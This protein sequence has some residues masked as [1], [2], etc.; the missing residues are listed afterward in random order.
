VTPNWDYQVSAVGNPPQKFQAMT[1]R[2]HLP[3]HFPGYETIMWMDADTWIQR[4]SAVEH[5][6]DKAQTNG[7][8]ICQE[9]DRAY[10]NVYDLNNSRV[11]FH[12]SLAIFGDQVLQHVGPLPMVNSGVFAMRSDCKYWSE[13]NA[14]LGSAIQRGHLDH[15]TEQT[16]LNVCVYRALPLPYFMPAKFNWLCI[17]A[18][19]KF[20]DQAML[21]VDPGVP[22]D[23]I[24]IIH[25]A[26]VH[27]RSKKSLVI[28]DINGKKTEMNLLYA[29]WK[30]HKNQRSG[31]TAFRS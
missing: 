7:L 13:W 17:H 31:V 22:H 29:Q 1:A 18:L 11:L 8:A 28:A 12:N 26:G 9:M 5:F 20:D 19:P 6:F 3:K 23:E 10:A 25:L 24:S 4:W 14:I 16:A 15:F 27:T 2:P 30:Q 21:Y